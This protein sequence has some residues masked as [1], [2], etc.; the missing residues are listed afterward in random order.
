ML[1]IN[2]LYPRDFFRKDKNRKIVRVIESVV[3]LNLFA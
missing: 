1:K 3:A 2:L